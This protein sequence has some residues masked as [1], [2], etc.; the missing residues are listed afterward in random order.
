LHDGLHHRAA[1]GHDFGEIAAPAIGVGAAGGQFLH[2][3]TGGK[4]RTAGGDHHR[5]HAFIVVNVRERRMQ[6]RNQSLRQ[7][8]AGFRPIERE[9]GNASKRLAKQVRR[10]RRGRTCSLARHRNIRLGRFV[11]L[12]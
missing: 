10:S 1:G 7:A 8:V 5:A 11:I 2:V 12:M 9:H 6:L 4:R 3:V